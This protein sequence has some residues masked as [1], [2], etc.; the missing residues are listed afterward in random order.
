[1]PDRLESLEAQVATLRLELEALRGRMESLESGA[2]GRSRTSAGGEAAG[3][4]AGAAA[5]AEPGTVGA[6]AQSVAPLVGRALLVLAGAFVL[7]ALTDAGTV[8]TAVG[9]ALGFAYAAGVLTLAAR[10][11]NP[12][13]AGVHAAT[14]VVVVFPLLHEATA[15]FHL[16]GPWTSALILALLGAALL[17]VATR[18]RLQ[19]V[20]WAAV[21]ACLATGTGLVLAT[22][23]IV[24]AALAV[25]ALGLHTLWVRYRTDWR[26]LRWP[27]AGAADLLVLVALGRSAAPGAA[28]GPALAFL[29]AVFLVVGYL[30]SFAVRTL[31]Q[32]RSATA[33][34]MAQTAGLLGAGLGGT[35]L[36]AV[37]SA[38]STVGLGAFSL[39]LAA[40]AYAVAYGAVERRQPGS[41]N[42]Q[43]YASLGLATLVAGSWLALPGPARAPA[44]AALALGAAALARLRTRRTLVVHAALLGAAAAGASGLLGHARTTILSFPAPAWPPLPA[45]TLAVLA[46]L[47]AAALLSA[48]SGTRQTPPERAVQLLLDAVVAICAAGVV[49]GWAVDALRAQGGAAEP[50]VVGTGRSAV[51]AAGAVL[52]AWLG[53]REAGREAGWLAWPLLALLGL[54]LVAE[55]F[56]R[57]RPATL[58]LSF[59]FAGAALILVPRLRARAR[60][61]DPDPVPGPP[62]AGGGR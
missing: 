19:G 56:P 29:A 37:R 57:G 60:G 20:A 13:A 28:E 23:R 39:A 49:A 24:P 45:V 62:A 55:D 5:A 7:R 41:T 16:L 42:F 59:A 33:F 53:R 44:L 32:G 6:L 18:R 21:A 15:R 14:A 2:A 36:L 12:T 22:G 30:G 4:A 43:F 26:L 38:S 8:P 10:A 3:P 51:L 54:K 46:C 52:A 11:A 17:L 61:A 47:A 50:G 1:V 48:R 31:H 27:M 35:A 58:I 25:T 40:G 34:E 9:V